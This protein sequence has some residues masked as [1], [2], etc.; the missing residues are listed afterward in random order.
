MNKQELTAQI[1]EKVKTNKATAER[2]INAFMEVVSDAI[3]K[4]DNV[5]LIGFGTFGSRERSARIARNPKTGSTVTVAAKT[6]PTFKAGKALK[7]AI[8]K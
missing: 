4:G 2:F 5:Q 6:V 1:M 7:E 3:A 8:N